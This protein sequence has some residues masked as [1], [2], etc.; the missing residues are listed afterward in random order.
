M[1]DMLYYHFLNMQTLQFHTQ[2]LIHNT[3]KI[4]SYFKHCS[5]N[6]PLVVD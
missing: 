6:R 4:I 2:P 1:T 3:Y 5:D